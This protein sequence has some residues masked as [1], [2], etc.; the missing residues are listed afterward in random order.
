MSFPLFKDVTKSLNELLKKGYPSAEK[1]SFRTEFD[2]TSSSGVQVTPYIQKTFENSIEGEL[3]TKFG[4]KE[5]QIT[6]TENLKQDVSFEISP[7]KHSSRGFKWTLNFS[8]NLTEFFDKVKGKISGELKNDYST[9]IITIEHP[10]KQS[11]SQKSDDSKL[12][13]NSVFGSKEK[14]FSI[15]V[16][17]EVSLS[18]HQPKTFNAIALIH[19]QDIDIGVFT[20]KKLGGSGST[21]VGANYFQK[22]DSVKDGQLGGEVSYDLSDKSSNLLLGA[23][24]KPSD[25][26]TFKTRFDSKGLL[27]FLYTEK[28]CGPLTVAFGA[29]W[30]ILGAG[31]PPPF[32]HSFKLLFK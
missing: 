20:K 22:V 18:T 30:N 2:T 16:D 31:N 6:T 9:S 8:S 26:A 12:L 11:S 27:G 25:S 17:T 28:W 29:D 14:G 24:F 7:A 13:F 15:G 32:Q 10:I 19:R 23:S 3:K 5:L 1:Y 21:V 4:Y